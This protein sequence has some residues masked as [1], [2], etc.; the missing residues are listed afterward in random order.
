MFVRVLNKCIG[1]GACAT[2]SPEVFEITKNYAIVNREKVEGNE[3]SCIEAALNC[4]ADAID[5]N[6]Y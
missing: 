4:P 2:L 6:E 1:C 5:L 3:E